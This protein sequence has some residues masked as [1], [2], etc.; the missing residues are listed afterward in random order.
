MAP[1]FSRV[2]AVGVILATTLALQGCAP[3]HL[4]WERDINF[5]SEPARVVAQK[6][7][8]SIRWVDSSESHARFTAQ[9]LTAS[10]YEREVC[11]TNRQR[12][13]IHGESWTVGALLV[14]VLILSSGE[15]PQSGD[16][17]TAL[18]AFLGGTLGIGLAADVIWFLLS[19]PP[20]LREGIVESAKDDGPRTLT[21]T[22][23]AVHPCASLTITD[24]ITGASLEM[25]TISES[26]AV[27]DAAT[28]RAVGFRS[29]E[30]E[31][32]TG[33]LRARADLPADFARSLK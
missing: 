5:G 9:V 24:P 17:L 29:A 18:L 31:F 8:I 25:L 12:L 16:G 13:T 10:T 30:L 3:I 19:V 14:F 28:L 6:D 23:E 33:D 11:V 15:S 2:S 22:L 7:T 21:F 4:A 32:S 26:G 1:R 27:I 20:A